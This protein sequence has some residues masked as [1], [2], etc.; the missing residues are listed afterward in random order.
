VS[1]DDGL[2]IVSFADGTRVTG[3]RLLVA[4]GRRPRVDRLGL[5][6]IGIE[7]SPRGIPV[8]GNRGLLAASRAEA[9]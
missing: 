7:A 3:E 1:R 9:I 6:K 2:Y 5:E 8:D 4:S